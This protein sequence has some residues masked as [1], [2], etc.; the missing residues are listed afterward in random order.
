MRLKLILLDFDGTLA[1]TREANASAYV[2]ALQE[3]GYR[4][5][6]E[7]YLKHYFG[8]RCP[9]FLR[10][11][12]FTDPAQIDRIRRRKIELYPSFFSTVR[13]NEPLWEFCR[14]FRRTGGRV[15]I[16]ST[17]QADNIRNAMRH[18]HLEGEVDGVLTADE[19]EHNK[20]APDAFL[21]AMEIEGCQPGETLIFEDSAVGVE[22]ARRSG[23]PY[24]VVRL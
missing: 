19:V 15:W 4:M 2:A 21:K 11:V 16:V 6:K 24:V 7:T 5:D 9:E 1:D 8:M 20:P 3:A 23:A 12:G 13:L 14:Q 18:L 10:S 22:A 17:G